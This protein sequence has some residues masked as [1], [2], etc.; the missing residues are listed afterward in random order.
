[1]EQFPQPEHITEEV[2]DE[3]T[4]ILLHGSIGRRKLIISRKYLIFAF[5][6]IDLIG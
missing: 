3:L 6:C 4:G 5:R 1:M 2:I